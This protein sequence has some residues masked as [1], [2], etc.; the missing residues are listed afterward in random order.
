MKAGKFCKIE[1]M[2]PEEAIRTIN[3]C[4]WESA[5]MAMPP[6]WE[7]KII[8]GKGRNPLLWGACYQIRAASIETAMQG[9]RYITS[10]YD[11]DGHK[12]LTLPEHCIEAQSFQTPTCSGCEL[13]FDSVTMLWFFSTSDNGS[14]EY[15]IWE[16]YNSIYEDDCTEINE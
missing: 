2:T 3:E 10:V 8:H 11:A 7:L 4:S 15:H 5:A 9:N 14:L 1:K 13:T 16:E 6:Y 12:V